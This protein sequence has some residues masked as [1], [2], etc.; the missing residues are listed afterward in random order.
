MRS[1]T[2]CARPRAPARCSRCS[3]GARRSC[4]TCVAGCRSCSTPRRAAPIG[5]RCSLPD[6]SPPR[7]PAVSSSPRKREIPTATAKS[8]STPDMT[9][10][11]LGLALISQEPIGAILDMSDSARHA[12]YE[13]ILNSAN[14]SLDRLRGVIATFRTDLPSASRE[15]VLDRAGRVRASCRGATAAIVE[16]ESLLAEGIYSR[17]AER[18]Q[19]QLKNGNAE[20]RRVF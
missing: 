4:V 16:V 18:E 12:R 10:L 1:L 19:A 8:A 11:L 6:G 14:D 5:R 7:V 15:L 2:F 3:A 20:I 17:R 9:P 13:R